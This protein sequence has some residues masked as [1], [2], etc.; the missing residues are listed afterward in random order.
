M[1]RKIIPAVVSGQTVYAVAPNDNVRTAAKIMAAQKIGAVMVM[2]GESLVGILTERDMTGRV[3]AKNR[4]PDEVTVREVMTADPDTL[5]PNDTAVDAIKLMK[6]RG[7]R[8]LPVKDGKKVVGMV[9]VRDLYAIYNLELEQDVRDR[10]AFIHGES[11]G[12][13]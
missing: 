12:L 8:H 5:A 9:S 13:G 11:Y 6:E 2:D 1:H 10:D 7:Y 3:I 4:D